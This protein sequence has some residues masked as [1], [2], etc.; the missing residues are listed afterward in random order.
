[1]LEAVFLDMDGTL[2]DTEGAESQ[3][4]MDLCR[5]HGTTLSSLDAATR[6]RGAK[7]ADNL[8]RCADLVASSEPLDMA[9][10]V[11]ARCDSIL[12]DSIEPIPG[13]IELLESLQT[14][15]FVV[16]NSPLAIITKRIR[17]TGMEHLLPGPHFSAYEVGAWKP[18]STLYSTAALM[19]GVDVKRS[20]AVEDSDVGARAAAGA[21]LRTIL[22]RHDGGQIRDAPTG[23]WQVASSLRDVRALLQDPI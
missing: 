23:V 18:D 5:L 10:W 3:A 8:Q 9:D 4:L 1:M 6:F 2:V 14:P 17:Q 20:V 16:S 12:G 13:A 22:L 15:R 21:G 11:R 19:S 7:L